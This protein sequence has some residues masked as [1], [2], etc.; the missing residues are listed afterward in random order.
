MKPEIKAKVDEFLKTHGRRELSMDEMDRVSGGIGSQNNPHEI[1]I[2]GVKVDEA[3]FNNMIIDVMDS[4]GYDVALQ[5]A[6]D[7]TN[8]PFV[9]EGMKT[10]R[11]SNKVNMEQVLRDFWYSVE[12]GN[13]MGH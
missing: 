7:L 8:Y 10:S 11:K 6:Q 2:E 3:A 1:Y 12:I 13:Y 4:F 5:V 9:G